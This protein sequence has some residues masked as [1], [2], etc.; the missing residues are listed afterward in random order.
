[1]ANGKYCQTAI[2]ICFV[3][4]LTI[5]GTNRL[6]TNEG[7]TKPPIIDNGILASLCKSI[8]RSSVSREEIVGDVDRWCANQI[9]VTTAKEAFCVANPSKVMLVVVNDYPNLNKHFSI[10]GKINSPRQEFPPMS[11]SRPFHIEQTP[12]CNELSAEIKEK[13]RGT[14]VRAIKHFPE[15]S[16][17]ANQLNIDG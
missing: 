15:E 1:M 5:L 7:I 13:Q 10:L 17:H 2:N 4:E 6:S 12:T 9:G 16:G 3:S 11:I 8:A 14:R